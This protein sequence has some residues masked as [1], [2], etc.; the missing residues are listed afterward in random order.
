MWCEYRLELIRKLARVQIHSYAEVITLTVLTDS[1]IRFCLIFFLQ[2]AKKYFFWKL[3]TA[4]TPICC[5]V[6]KVLL[7]WW[8]PALELNNLPESTGAAIYLIHVCSPMSPKCH[9]AVVSPFFQLIWVQNITVSRFWFWRSG[10][11][12]VMSQIQDKI[13]SLLV[14]LQVPRTWMV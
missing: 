7:P 10:Y 1:I 8:C 2:A 9:L 12:D 14:N 6:F 5:D 11:Q 3:L 13:L 4:S